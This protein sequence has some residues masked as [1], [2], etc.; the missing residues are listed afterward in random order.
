MIKKL[1]SQIVRPRYEKIKLFSVGKQKTVISEPT[2]PKN[3]DDCSVEQNINCANAKRN[4]FK[5]KR[6][7]AVTTIDEHQLQFVVQEH[8][9]DDDPNLIYDLNS[10]LEKH[11]FQ[12]EEH[13]ATF[14]DFIEELSNIDLNVN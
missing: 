1:I 9:F 3:I 13:N 4:D 2:L 12:D 6:A 14:D 5:A 10:F 7:N 8:E 11:P